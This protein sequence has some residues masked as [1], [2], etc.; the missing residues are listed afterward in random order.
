M[1]LAWLYAER[2]DVG[3]RLRLPRDA[4]DSPGL[5]SPVNGW[6]GSIGPSGAQVPDT[7]T[8]GHAE[9]EHFKIQTL[10]FYS[11]HELF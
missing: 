1:S 8:R 6:I 4:S 5:E 2:R 11:K 3:R 10:Q 9:N 7:G